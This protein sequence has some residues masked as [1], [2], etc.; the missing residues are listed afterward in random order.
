MKRRLRW[1]WEDPI[2][3]MEE[4]HRAW[5]E[6][7]RESFAPFFEPWEK[8]F[9]KVGAW[10]PVDIEETDK[11]IIVKADLP[12]FTKDE[13]SVE[14]V[15][16]RL[17]ISAKKKEEKVEQDKNYYRRERMGKLASR[18]ITLP[19]EVDAENA[20]VEFENGVLTITLPKKKVE[21]KV[22]LL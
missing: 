14:V 16:D 9:E 4:M 5:E 17:Q 11:E 7:F 3:M 2:A 10:M 13:V 1:F 6:S 20:K 18:S 8:S 19:C 22:K 12:G 15:G 21:K